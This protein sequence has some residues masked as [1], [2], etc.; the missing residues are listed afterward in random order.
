MSELFRKQALERRAGG[1]ARG[2]IV[3]IAPPWSMAVF[4]VMT[5]AL[6]ALVALVSVGEG[7]VYAGGRGVVVS[8][9]PPLVVRA[10]MAG[11]VQTVEVAPGGAAKKRELL[12]SLDVTAQQAALPICRTRETA[13]EDEYD[14]VSDRMT[15]WGKGGRDPALAL[16]LISESRQARD[17]LTATREA[18]AKLQ[19]EI[20]KSRVLMPLDA[21]VDELAVGPGSPVHADDPLATLAPSDGHLVATIAVPEAHRTELVLG[22]PVRLKFDALPFDSVG[23]GSGTITRVLDGL[24]NGVKIDGADPSSA[25][26]EVSIDRMPDSARAHVG[27]KLAVDVFVTKKKLGALLFGGP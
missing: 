26:A 23:V 10:P 1:E 20:D 15:E 7:A 6:V 3:A 18:C 19:S 11:N 16:V 8:S 13:Q 4:G 17:K 5:V 12:L 9:R 14:R 25:Y 21:V 2:V 24:P 22:A 27:M